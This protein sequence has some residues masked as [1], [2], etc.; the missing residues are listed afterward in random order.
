MNL[1]QKGILKLAVK[2]GFIKLNT[3]HTGNLRYFGLE[4]TIG[5]DTADG[6]SKLIDEGFAYNTDVHAITSKL[7]EKGS[8]IPFILQEQTPD[9]WEEVIDGERYDFM[10]EPNPKQ[11]FKQFHYESLLYLLLTGDLFWRTHKIIGFGDAIQALEILP[12][13]VTDVNINANYQ[14]TGYTVTL[15]N[16]TQKVPL[17][18]V[19]H[20]MYSNPTGS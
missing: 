8:D 5:Y 9:G 17:D 1:I 13:N 4:D 14:K 10:Q 19:I 11:T 12:S 3:R 2:S 18:E 20:E 6:D 16:S 15:G 7:S